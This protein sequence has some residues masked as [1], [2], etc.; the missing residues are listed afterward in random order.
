MKKYIKHLL[1]IPIIMFT[2]SCDDILEEDISDES[3]IIIS[4]LDNDIIEGNS[5]QFRWNSIEGADSYRLQIML[6]KQVIVLDSLVETS[7]FN[8]QISPGSYSWRLRAENF[9]YVTPFT[10]E[11]NFSVEESLDL[12]NQTVTLTNPNENFYTNDNSI[13]FTWQGIGTAD[14]YEFELLTSDNNSILKEPNLTTPSF[15]IPNNTISE[16]GEYIWKVNAK[17]ENS[18][19][20]DFSRTF[21]IDTEN[22]SSPT[23]TSPTADQIFTTQQDITFSWSYVDQGTVKSNISSTLEISKDE[24]FSDLESSDRVIDFEL[25]KKIETAGK[26]YWRVTGEDEAGNIGE[27]STVLSFTVN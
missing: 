7:T 8:Y 11:T 21:F 24:V 10:F 16:D 5:V 23:T 25:T 15:S 14:F 9:A 13:N 12:T 26:Y 20:N 22:P 3:V 2:L 17:N 4:P 1:F 27:E 19:T 6:D 18:A